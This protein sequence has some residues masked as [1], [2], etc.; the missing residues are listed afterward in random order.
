MSSIL[1]L[2]AEM[3]KCFSL[4]PEANHWVRTM[5]KIEKID[6]N[7]SASDYFVVTWF[8]NLFFWDVA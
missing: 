6:L 5:S 8:N 4:S 2:F 1:V 7:V 3:P